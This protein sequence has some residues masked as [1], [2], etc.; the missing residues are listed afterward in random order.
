M[1]KIRNS[2]NFKPNY[3]IE[4][5]YK[6]YSMYNPTELLSVLETN[7]DGLDD[8]SVSKK[9][10]KYGPNK[11]VNDK[12]I[13]WYVF[14]TKSFIDE[15]II[16][17]LLLGFIS[18]FLDDK[19]GAL[20]ILI[21]ALISALIRFIQDFK[22]YLA[23][24][25]L[26]K[27]I[28]TIVD[29][30]RNNELKEIPIT[31]LTIG[32]IV[33]IG[34]GSI[35]PADLII[36][37][38]KD[39]FISQSM[40]TG[41]SVPIEKKEGIYTNY[42]SATE[43]KNLCLMG[44]TVVS[45]SGTGVVVKIGKETYLGHIS[46]I[47]ESKKIKTNFEVGLEKITKTMVRYMIAVVLGVFFINGFFKKDWLS[48]LLFSISVAVGITPGMLPLIIN[49]T[50][51]KGSQFLAKKKTIV[52]NIASIQNLGAIDVL[53]TDKTG[54]LTE[55]KIVFHKY[56][57]VNG[58]EDKKILDYVYLNSYF[59][60]GIK[61]LIDYAI[62]EFGE[63]HEANED[64]KLYKKIDEIPFDYNRRRMS[65]VIENDKGKHRIITKGALE[66]V[67]D[68]CTNVKYNGDNQVLTDELI[69]KVISHSDELSNDGM[70]VIAVAEKHVQIDID[71]F[72]TKDESEMTFLGY[73]AFL[74][75]PKEDAIDAIK[76][77]Y[78]AGV[79][80]KVISG[81]S[82]LTVQYTCKNVGIKPG[83]TL[84]GTDIEIMDDETL[85]KAVDDAN[86]FA[87]VSPNQKQRVVDAL[88]SNG[89]VVGYMGDG[90]NDAP[91][92]HHADVG[93]SVDN[94]KDI[95][96]ESAD[97]I[98]LEKSLM[99]LLDGIYEGR[100]VYGNVV[101]YMKMALSSNFGN[102]FSVLFASLFLP[103]LPMI[104]IQIL[105][106]NLIYDLTQIAIPWDGVDSEFLEL[107]KK[108]DTKGLSNFMNVMGVT[109]SIF[110]MIIFGV[111]WFVLGYSSIYNQ[112]YFQ[113]GWFIEGLISQTIVVHFIRTSK[114]PFIQSR[115]N[116]RLILSTIG[117]VMAAILIPYLLQFINGFNF[118]IMPRVYY[119]YLVAVIMGYALTIQF[120]KKIY[121]K[122]YGTWL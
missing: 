60:T 30:K 24:E 87:R 107:P 50:L 108:W 38:S 73:A 51:S 12:S 63:A 3:E 47:V 114:I 39:L 100:R 37:K 98:L 106:Q 6:E 31:E 113:T 19:L 96:K 11:T 52:K 40:F 91:S 25:K 99:V 32:D 44:C 109:S 1:I 82:H 119:G 105:I 120:V 67:L 42:I 74:D 85:K 80:V 64:V 75:P 8:Y 88:R 23:S 21:I 2:T 34:N 71:T 83:K 7:E 54:T 86:I 92:L 14:L 16:V 93:I 102:V 61:N 59:S 97:I 90:V 103:F 48:A 45:G 10:E 116:I 20:I 118:E 72:N 33:E 95:A 36:L 104:P 65:V 94:A 110:D 66:D 115:A 46:K 4:D 121:I 15:F 55:D 84:L 69:S 49:S 41:E 57:N 76:Q 43:Q 17:L 56:I 22:A 18:F 81:D 122:I 62:I 78:Q 70:H 89:H 112:T 5:S 28:H 35:I 26:K 27:M 68:I 111:L 77:L 117:G 79:D 58:V 53:C 101:K 13:P 29:V 9:I